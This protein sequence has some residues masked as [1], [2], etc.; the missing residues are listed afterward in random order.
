MNRIK[1]L[2]TAVGVLTVVGSA[3]AY[4][5]SFNQKIC[6]VARPAGGC[7]TSVNCTTLAAGK[8]TQTGDDHCYRVVPA[9]TTSCSGITCPNQ[10]DVID[11]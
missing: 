1:V 9:N 3:L 11:N 6:F 10:A 5:G 8:T 7:S 4:S 2:L